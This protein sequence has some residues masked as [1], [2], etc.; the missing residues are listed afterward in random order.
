MIPTDYARQ[1]LSEE[2]LSDTAN[3]NGG[4]YAH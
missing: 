3:D 2:S 1:R 4:A